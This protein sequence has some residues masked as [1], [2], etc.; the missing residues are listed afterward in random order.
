MTMTIQSGGTTPGGGL[1][2]G[3]AADLYSIIAGKNT[4]TTATVSGAPST[5]TSSTTGGGSSSSGS[6]S[7][8]G[9]QSSSGSTA[10]NTDQ[11]SISNQSNLGTSASSTVSNS[12]TSN[13]SRTKVGGRTD[14]NTTKSVIS[15]EA[16]DAMLQASLSKY[17]GLA[18]VSQGVRAGGGY[19][20]STNTLLTNDL[21]TRAAA[22]VAEA[23]RETTST[24]VIGDS[25]NDTSGSSSTT[26]TSFTTGTNSSMGTTNTT[27]SS[28]TSGTSNSTGTNTSTGSTSGSTATGPSSTT[29]NT[30][31]GASTTHTNTTV[32]GLGMGGLGSI[33]GLSVGV[34]LLSS[35]I[36]SGLGSLTGLLSGKGGGTS[37]LD[38]S[39]ANPSDHTISDQIYGTGPEM[40]NLFTMGEVDMS[41]D[42]PLLSAVPDQ[43][44]LP[45]FEFADGGI[46][47]G[48]ADGGQV[49]RGY[50]DDLTIIQQTEGRDKEQADY[51]AKHAMSRED[52]IKKYGETFVA[53]DKGGNAASEVAGQNVGTYYDKYLAKDAKGDSTRDY[54]NGDGTEQ[55]SMPSFGWKYR[56]ANPNFD[57]YDNVNPH[58]VS[59]DLGAVGEAWKQIGRPVATAAATYYTMG[60]LTGAGAGAA[61][62]T[63]GAAGIGS[64]TALGG[65]TIEAGGFAGALGM[66]AGTAATA[67]NSGSLN[68]ALKLVN[69]SNIGDALK[70]GLISA[71]TAGIGGA[72][73]MDPTT[74]IAMSVGNKLTGGALGKVASIGNLIANPSTAGVA[75]FLVSASPAGKLIN[76]IAGLTGL[77]KVGN[78]VSSMIAGA[79]TGGGLPTMDRSSADQA[80]NVVSSIPVDE[81]VAAATESPQFGVTSGDAPTGAYADGELVTGQKT[82]G[83]LEDVADNKTVK[84]T[85]GEFI[86]PVDVVEKPGVLDYLEKLVKQHHVPAEVQRAKVRMA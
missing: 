24:N 58:P 74:Q 71:A 25:Y 35:A 36:T 22:A 13:S 86:V 33:L 21:L 39:G 70:S 4:N 51:T 57:A 55:Y 45:E 28:N 54:I 77:P 27:G 64:G 3:G 34:P 52:F 38:F 29:V 84:V 59:Q 32:D 60:A 69:G 81:L 82:G 17:D 46:V 40:D 14:V 11:N 63:G 72:P 61:V 48:Y 62:G 83:P 65:A 12:V 26:G 2:L 50:G 80:A 67:L 31:P 56:D 75:N 43:F 8:S 16:M 42:N 20:G 5:S 78:I 7:S 18:S 66:E 47:P 79:N 15:K 23:T 76:S 10:S 73:T 9:S 85:P 19:G 49:T 30:T 41:A 53:D 44:E 37:D 68:T 1:S 6:T